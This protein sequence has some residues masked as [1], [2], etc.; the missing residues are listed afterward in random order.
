M[1]YRRPKQGKPHCLVCY[2]A[3]NKASVEKLGIKKQ[4]LK[5]VT[6]SCMS[7][8]AHCEEQTFQQLKCFGL[9]RIFDFLQKVTSRSK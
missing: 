9:T 7:S 8:V 5:Q 4:T 3:W 2:Y 6:L 1:P